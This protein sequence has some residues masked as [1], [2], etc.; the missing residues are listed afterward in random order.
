MLR[1]RRGVEDPQVPDE[2]LRANDQ[3]Q[4]DEGVDGDTE[5]QIHTFVIQH[6]PPVS[7]T[8]VMPVSYPSHN[9]PYFT[10]SSHWLGRDKVSSLCHMLDSI[11]KQ[12]PGQEVVY[13]WVQWLQSSALSHL[14][15]DDGI[16]LR[17]ADSTMGA[18]DVW[19]VVEIMSLECETVCLEDEDNN[20][21]CSKGFFNFCTR[22]RVCRHIG[23][24]C[25]ILT[26]EE[27][28]LS[29][30]VTVA[31]NS[32]SSDRER[33]HA[34][35]KGNTAKRTNLV[36]EMC[37]IKELLRDAV[38]CPHCRIAISCNHMYCRN[39][40]NSFC[41]D[42]GKALDRNHTSTVDFCVKRL[43]TTAISSAGRAKSISALCLKVVRKSSEH[44]GP[45][46]RCRQYS[47]W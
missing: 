32:L 1:A 9:H 6:L 40:G 16:V 11:W 26:P 5:I 3:L 7:L 25:V 15:F 8:C 10:L 35:N 21:Q 28:L 33:M 18:V 24:K 43:D 13:E 36:N 4:Q 12:Q 27:K 44:Y 22:C 38:P 47:G 17:Q 31:A 30:L 23:E 20:A 42:C 45:R 2:Q 46:G 19:A 14:G 37:S 34:T 39:C 41:Y 29:L